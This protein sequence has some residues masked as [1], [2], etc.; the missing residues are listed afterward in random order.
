MSNVA[1]FVPRGS[2]GKFA[3]TVLCRKYS[4]YTPRRDLYANPAIISRKALLV[5]SPVIPCTLRC[6]YSCVME[7]EIFCVNRKAGKSMMLTLILALYWPSVATGFDPSFQEG[8]FCRSILWVYCHSRRA[9]LPYMD[10]E[11]LSLSREHEYHTAVMNRSLNAKE[12]I[13]M[14]ICC[15]SSFSLRQRAETSEAL[16]RP[17]KSGTLQPPHFRSTGAGQYLSLYSESHSYRWF[18][19]NRFAIAYA[20]LQIAHPLSLSPVRRQTPLFY[21]RY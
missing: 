8:P 2:S 18:C 9:V 1:L 4:G 17:K 15:K 14:K 5:G 11:A 16:E 19:Q 20:L 6:W 3:R 10:I 21:S 7:P 13:K 12:S